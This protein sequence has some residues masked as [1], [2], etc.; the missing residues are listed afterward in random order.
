MRPR[1]YSES[2]RRTRGCKTATAAPNSNGNNSDGNN[3][4]GTDERDGQHY[5]LRQLWD[6]KGSYDI[7]E[8]RPS[9]FRAYVRICAWALART[10]TR[11]G[12]PAI[13]SGYIGTSDTFPRA[14]ADF[15]EAN[16]HQTELDHAALVAAIAAGRVAA[17]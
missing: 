5:F 11:G 14:I 12:H 10:H 9:G 17:V 2:R 6:A 16:A 1:C 3:S 4:N 15:T 13:I 7:E 8:M